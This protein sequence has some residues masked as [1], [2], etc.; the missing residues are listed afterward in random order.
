MSYS[1]DLDALL[2]FNTVAQTRNM[3]LGAERLHITQPPLS[4]KI[5][6]LEASL[7]FEL[8][9]RN[10][11]GLE[12][13][14]RGKRVLEIIQSLLAEY[15]QVAASLGELAKANERKIRLG[16]TT[17]FEQGIFFALLAEL[18]DKLAGAI[19]R[20]T[21]PALV[22]AVLAGKLDAALVALPTAARG[23]QLA[24]LAYEEKIII[25]MPEAWPESA[26]LEIDLQSVNGRPLFW[27][28]RAA[29]PEYFDLARAAF[30]QAQYKPEYIQE[31]LEHDVLLSRIANGEGMALLPE[32]FAKIRR[33]GI[34]FLPLRGCQ[35][36]LGLGLVWNNA[37][38]E[39]L[40]ETINGG[41][42]RMCAY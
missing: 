27:F 25:A 32:S 10:S 11:R 4:R 39:S 21:S 26:S 33:E 15:E 42:S 28:Q 5:Q 19:I 2:A 38:L 29:N 14:N 35:L 24:R 18:A 9:E 13:T 6:R 12:L 17:A 7:G 3:R 8:F 16:I 1:P 36:K 41:A 20:K 40:L 37:G 23:L 22:K 31:P 34:K 30:H